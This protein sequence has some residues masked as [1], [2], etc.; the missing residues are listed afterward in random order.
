[1]FEQRDAVIAS[2]FETRSPR[3]RADAPKVWAGSIDGCSGTVVVE[4]D[5]RVREPRSDDEWEAFAEA[6]QD[7]LADLDRDFRCADAARTVTLIDAYAA[8]MRDLGNRFGSEYG[9]R[10][11]LGAQTFFQSTGL[12]L[13]MSPLRVAHMVDAAT[14]LRDDLPLTWNTYLDGEATWN[15]VN[16][17]VQEAEGLASAHLGAYDTEAAAAVVLTPASRLK[18]KL[19]SIRE[20]L[21]DDTAGARAKRTRDMRRVVIEPGHDGEA[22]ITAIGPAIPIIGFDQ[23]LTK[24]AIAARLQEGETRSIGQLRFDVMMD[25]LVEG[26]KQSADPN[27][28]GLKVPGRKGVIPAPVLMIPALSA[29]GKSKEQARLIGYGPIAVETAKEI[30]GSAT[31][32]IRVLTDP[33]TGVRL[34]MDR[35][36]RIP[37]I[38]MRRWVTIRDELCRFPGCNRAA[39]LCDLD[40]VAEWQHLGVTATDNLVSLSRPHHRAKSAELWT[41][42]LLQNGTVD[43][44]DP[45]GGTFTDPPPNPSDPAPPDLVERARRAVPDECPF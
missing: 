43:W 2:S 15:A 14:T 33:I 4:V 24:A 5:G 36:Q 1:M 22:A 8:S 42:E 17:A 41:E 6:Q 25:L 3:P 12:R 27:W 39:H 29:L 10:D 37:P 13:G 44:E 28:A 40:H 31:S 38:D 30:A 34:D 20:R 26:I 9:R 11:S 18:A 35:K 19:H 23:A 32:F 7:L 45:W 16:R 21:Q